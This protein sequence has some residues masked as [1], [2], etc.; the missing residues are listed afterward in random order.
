MNETI[1]AF[2]D[3]ELS[4]SEKIELV[5]KLSRDETFA[6]ETLA[7]LRQETRIR[8]ALVD[9][10]PEVN[11]DGSDGWKDFFLSLLQPLRLT[12]AALAATVVIVLLSYPAPPVCPVFKRFVIYRP[13]VSRVDIT[14]SFTTWQRVPMQPVGTSG[15]W[16]IQLPLPA[17][18]HRYTYILEGSE[19][20]ADPTVSAQEKDDFGGR[21]SIIYVGNST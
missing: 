7:L 13:D 5:R 12:A 21:N 16:E 4:L 19:S 6:G 14:G 8:S 20:M 10:V 18:E 3:D 9:R 17:G 15:Y 2:I 11:F 1:S